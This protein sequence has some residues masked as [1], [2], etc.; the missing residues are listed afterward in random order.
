MGV[1]FGVEFTAHIMLAF[2][3]SL[4]SNEE[5]IKEAMK[6]MLPPTMNGACSTIVSVVP[7]LF[8]DF[9]YIRKY[10]FV[11]FVLLVLISLLNGSVLMPIV[12][13]YAGPKSVAEQEGTPDAGT[14]DAGTPD[15]GVVPSNSLDAELA[16]TQANATV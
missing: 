8:G 12:L 1:A 10:M 7:L 9:E 5:R 13:R 15:A 3:T 16:K 2:M 4:G 14:P 11:P 6:H